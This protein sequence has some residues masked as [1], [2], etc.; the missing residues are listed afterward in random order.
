MISVQ[1][2]AKHFYFVA[3]DLKRYSAEEYYTLIKRIAMQCSGVADDDLVTVSSSVADLVKIFTN[4]ASKPEGQANRINTE[5]MNL[6]TP[7]IQAGVTAQNEEWIAAAA[8][9]EVIRQNNWNITDAAIA[10]G[11]AFIQ[12]S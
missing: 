12:Q 1:L 11:K 9:I 8:Q 7:Q 10:A 5:M 4:I 6:I 3:N 2:K